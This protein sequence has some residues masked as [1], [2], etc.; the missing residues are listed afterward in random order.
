MHLLPVVEGNRTFI[1]W[2][3]KLDTAPGDAD[4]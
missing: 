4:R 2:S 3:V 1:E